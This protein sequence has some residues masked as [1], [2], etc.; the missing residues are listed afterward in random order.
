MAVVQMVTF[1]RVGCDTV[2][3]EV[4]LTCSEPLSTSADSI[5]AAAAKKFK[6]IT[7]QSR[8]YHGLTGVE[9]IG[10]VSLDHFKGA[11]VVLSGKGGW[12]GAE[13]IRAANESAQAAVQ[14]Q[15]EQ[16]YVVHAA[17]AAGEGNSSRG[18]WDGVFRG[19]IGLDVGGVLNQ[20]NNDVAS[21]KEWW[22]N[23]ESEA[24]N[25]MR[26][27][28]RIV[29]IFGPDNVFVVSKLG[30]DMQKLTETWLLETMD[31]CGETGLRQENIHFCT[32]RSG[33]QG[34]GAVASRLQLSHFVD[35]NFECLNSLFSDPAGNS[36]DHVEQQ[37]G[38][39]LH[40]A[41]SGLGTV[42]PDQPK[43]PKGMASFYRPVANW[44]EAMDVLDIAP[45]GAT[46][47]EISLSNDSLSELLRE[48]AQVDRANGVVLLWKDTEDNGY[49][50]NWGKSTLA[51]EG[52]SYGCVEQW[53]MASKASL[54]K[55]EAVREQ[56]MA[57]SNPRKQKALGRS[58]DKKMVTRCWKVPQKWAVQLQGA[59]AKF[60]QNGKLAVKLLRTGQ[61]RIA[62]AS[63]SDSV[64]GIGLSPSNPLA[65]DPANWNGLNLLGR[66]LEKVREE[67]RQHILKGEDLATL[68][69]HDDSECTSISQELDLPSSEAHSEAEDPVTSEDEHA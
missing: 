54:C 48:A 69:L 11:F 44:C 18:L 9:L 26:S 59:R 20:H 32:Q 67:V 31:I 49:L 23:R 39:L 57:T 7:K 5:V 1:D 56:V 64:F 60:Q 61:K 68:P 55:D 4:A 52:V 29:E 45:S 3:V 6:S 27:V 28:R 35:D 36:R 33:R 34:K 40:F 63:P 30:S 50:S 42:R 38:H 22:L 65:Q 14:T 43:L 37:R 10:D 25:A 62:E 24:P 15:K 17:P 16:G 8:A 2:P 19:R 66:A 12:K 46:D 58:L 53:L 47:D 51:I 21:S 13:R 41:R